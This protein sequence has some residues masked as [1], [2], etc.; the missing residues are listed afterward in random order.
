MCDCNIT[1]TEIT[2]LVW[3]FRNPDGGN[4]AITWQEDAKT[5]SGFGLTSNQAKVY[6]SAVQLG[7]ASASGISRASKVRREQV[8]RIL[9]TL[10]KAGLV[11]RVLGRPTRFRATPLEET[12]SLL[13]KR[14]EER[15]YSRISSLKD[16]KEEF[17]KRFRET[18]RRIRFDEEEENQFVLTSEKDVT[19]SRLDSMIRKAKSNIDIVESRQKLSQLTF[20]CAKSFG[21]AD[22]EGIR[23]RIITELPDEEDTIPVDIENHIPR[24]CFEL[25]YVD[26][27]PSHFIV[28]DNNEA[29]VTT[30]TTEPNLGESPYLWTDNSSLVSLIQ[31]DFEDLFHASAKWNTIQHSSSEKARRFIRQLKPTDHT[32]FVYDS[33]ETKRNVLFNYI[34]HALE[35]GEAAA[36]VCS[37]EDPSDIKAAMEQF[38]IPTEKHRETGALRILYYTDFCMPDGKFSIPNTLNLWRGFYKQA[39]NKGFKGL[40]VTGEMTCFFKHRLVK[41]L[42]EYERALHKVLEIP[43]VAMCAY[44]GDMLSKAADPIDLYTEL[45]NAHGTILFKGMDTRLSRIRMRKN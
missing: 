5:L 25:R 44:N 4:V 33:K 37:E 18:S 1:L 27:L 42:V 40:R 36:Y 20:F 15:A 41:D 32:I 2:A 38:G 6:I 12:L 7:L 9:P 13:V 22:N 30:S 21:K 11:E 34:K 31:R 14:E 43:M 17:L 26:S 39:L 16:K 29:I 10:E 23:I 35:N 19:I 28:V 8:Y 3:L 24:N 45:V